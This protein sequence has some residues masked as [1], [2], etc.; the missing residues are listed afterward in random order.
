M[1]FETEDD[2]ESYS[3]CEILNVES[4]KLNMIPNSDAKNWTYAR[5]A[6]ESNSLTDVVN[7]KHRRGLALTTQKQFQTVTADIVKA[8]NSS[9][10]KAE[11]RIPSENIYQKANVNNDID[12]NCT[13]PT[14]N[15]TRNPCTK[16]PSN[17]QATEDPKGQNQQSTLTGSDMTEKEESKATGSDKYNVTT[18]ETTEMEYPAL[19]STGCEENSNH[20]HGSATEN[21]VG[22]RAVTFD[23]G[24]L[25]SRIDRY[26]ES[27]QIAMIAYKK[28]LRK[29]ITARDTLQFVYDDLMMDMRFHILHRMKHSLECLHQVVC[30]IIPGPKQARYKAI[31]DNGINIDLVTDSLI[32]YEA[33]KYIFPKLKDFLDNFP[34]NSLLPRGRIVNKKV[35][36][37]MQ[38]LQAL[39]VEAV[40]QGSLPGNKVSVHKI[41]HD[42][43]CGS[44][45]SAGSEEFIEFMLKETG[46]LSDIHVEQ[47]TDDDL[48]H[49]HSKIH[50]LKVAKWSSINENHADPLT[51]VEGE[52][53]QGTL[54]LSSHFQENS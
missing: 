3:K 35:P 27:L 54:A 7:K 41:A 21:G 48:I 15:D 16:I 52:H 38:S 6:S 45:N 28:M 40:N 43:T 47:V 50:N 25:T 29:V 14:A 34:A 51:E 44:L 53:H 31:I 46:V 18:P 1:S 30:E 11:D 42:E 5:N 24:E 10:N 26:K 39:D 37:S 22:N 32:R 9:D 19:G 49:E 33:Q 13:G 4:I 17:T 23:E 12:N 8:G 20:N 2:G 36:T